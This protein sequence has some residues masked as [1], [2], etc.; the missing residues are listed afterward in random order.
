MTPHCPN[1][2]F[3]GVHRDRPSGAHVSA[4]QLRRTALDVSKQQRV[5][6]AH[7]AAGPAAR[8]LL[9]VGLPGP[10]ILVTGRRRARRGPLAVAG[11]RG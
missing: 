7:H 1:D 9:P 5:H 6:A 3:P 4:A 10:A 8:P 11:T 2:G